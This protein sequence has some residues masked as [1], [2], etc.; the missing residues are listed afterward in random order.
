VLT[1]GE[2][3]NNLI[4]SYDRLEKVFDDRIINYGI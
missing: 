2:E 3:K 1:G 4:Q